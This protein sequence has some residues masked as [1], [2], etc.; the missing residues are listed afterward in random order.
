MLSWLMLEICLKRHREKVL[1]NWVTPI[2]YLTEDMFGTHVCW[3]F[4]SV[5]K[6]YQFHCHQFLDMV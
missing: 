3:A 1:N 4:V 2:V 6:P 5:T